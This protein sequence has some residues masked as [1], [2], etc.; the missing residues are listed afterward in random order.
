MMTT[1]TVDACPRCGQ[2]PAVYSVK[3]G[4]KAISRQLVCSNFDCGLRTRESV[5]LSAVVKSWNVGYSLSRQ[6]GAFYSDS[7]KKRAVFEMAVD[8]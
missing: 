5:D 4:G 7:S 8:V 3:R 6:G 1:I 2:R